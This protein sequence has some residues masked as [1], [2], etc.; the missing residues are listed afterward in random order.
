VRLAAE[1]MGSILIARGSC[2]AAM[3]ATSAR[4][5]RLGPRGRAPRELSERTPIARASAWRSQCT[6]WRTT[7]RRRRRGLSQSQLALVTEYIEAHLGADVS[8]VRLACFGR[9]RLAPAHTLQALDG[10]SGARIRHPAPRPSRDRAPDRVRSA[11]ATAVSS[12][13][14]RAGSVSDRRNRSTPLW[15]GRVEWR[16]WVSARSS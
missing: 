4:A 7:P 3:Y 6:S 8:L 1:E 11:R 2:L 16:G 14:A 12:A 9:E 10:S 13:K 5:H 15:R